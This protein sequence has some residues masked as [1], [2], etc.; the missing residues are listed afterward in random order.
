M[1][2]E[3]L[4]HPD[5][6][7][8]ISYAPNHEDILLDRVFGDHV[9]TFM[10]VG[11]RRPAVHNLTYFFYRR[12]WRGVNLEPFPRRHA[13]FQA[14]RPGDLNLPLAAWDS[15]GEIPFFEIATDGG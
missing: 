6:V 10:D 12:G 11:A 8:R 14:V 1:S 5:T 2:Q 9:G 7:P 15:N 3:S 13:E 4:L